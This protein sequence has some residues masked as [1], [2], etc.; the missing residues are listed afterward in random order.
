MSRPV[1]MAE[2]RVRDLED[3]ISAEETAATM[4]NVGGCEPSEVKVDSICRATNGLGTTWIKCPFITANRMA[5]KGVI[6]LGWTRARV[7]MLS[8]RP[9]Q[10]YRCL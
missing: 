5:R 4:A 2:M 3:S 6:Q 1:K 8:E 7:E 10:C 9:F